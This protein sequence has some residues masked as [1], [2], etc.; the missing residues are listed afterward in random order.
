VRVGIVTREW[1]PDVYGGAGVHVEH[2]VAA[3]RG[4]D[5]GPEIDVHAFGGPRFPGQPGYPVTG[6]GVPPGLQSANGALQAVGVDVE[7][8]AAL[9][10][11]DLVH[12][13]TWYANHAGHL[14][15]LLHGAAHVVTAHSL[16]PR[17]PWKADQLGGGYRLSSWIERTAYLD[18][19]AVIAVSRGM[20]ADVL[21]VYPDLDPARVHVVGNGVDAQAYRP[22]ESPDVVRALGVDPDRPYALFVGRITRQKGLLHLLAAA[23]QLPPE[24]GLVL[25]AG[26]A[27]TPDERTQVADA[28]A[29]LQTRRSGVV[30]IE[31]MLPRE[32]LVPLI[33]GATVFVVPSV[34]EPLGIVNLEAAA[35]GTAVV[36][37]DVG[38]IPEVVDDGRT[39]LL[40]HYDADRPAE[41][42]AGLAARMA[43]LLADP[44]RAAAM[45]A[46]GR[47]RVL[48]E[49]G[50]PAIAQQTVQVYE[51]VLASRS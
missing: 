29:E 14:A 40:V 35:C 20:R 6:Y 46:A 44:A 47:E 51:T 27:D 4:L 39:G 1:P 9:D 17:R 25:C 28:V 50:W 33:T 49:F 30:W 21:D 43:E 45:G 38:G 48:A 23:E 32:Q 41:F 10:R 13:H 5:D 7:I 19:D 34:Y 22:V 11:V 3:L 26:A 2:L 12:S 18:A 15:K 42:A 37:S 24:A 31:Q 8:A 16:E 36:A